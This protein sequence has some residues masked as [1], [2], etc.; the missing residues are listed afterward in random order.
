MPA[1]FADIETARLR[2]T[3]LPP[4]ASERQRRYFLDNRGHLAPWEPPR[5][6]GFF[7]D[8]YWRWRLEQNRIDCA[9]DRS[10]RLS[11]VGRDEPDGPVLG[12]VSLTEFVRGPLQACNL[13]YSLDH[14]RQGQGLMTEA[15]GALVPYAFDTMRFHRIHAGYLPENERSAR[16]LARLG[17]EVE[18]TARAYLFING[19]WR[20]HVLT[21]LINPTPMRPPMLGG[22]PLGL[23]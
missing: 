11:L 1:S 8:D 16:L 3:L 22:G 9:D 2:L 19:A 7:T 23:R 20:D 21:A 5:P 15:L 4:S 18:G 10:L 6:P 14:R 12:Q 17:F 13:G